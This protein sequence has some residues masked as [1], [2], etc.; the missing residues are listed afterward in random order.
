MTPPTSPLPSLMMSINAWRS[1]LSA[2]ARRRS[3][4]SK[5]GLSRLT[6]RLRL[7]PL[8]ASSQI[9][10][11]IWAFRSFE[12]RDLEGLRKSHVKLAGSERQY[13]RRRIFYDRIFDA[14]EKRPILL[15]VIRISRHL[16]GLVRLEFDEFERAGA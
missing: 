15:P 3:E 9:A 14:V 8:G 16:N 7:M 13:R 10:C 4:L 12:Q 6:S 11:G 5:G 1:K 2:I